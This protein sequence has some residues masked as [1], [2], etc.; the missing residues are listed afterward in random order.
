M[1]RTESVNRSREEAGRVC[2]FRGRT[3]GVMNLHDMVGA[4]IAL[5]LRNVR[6][7]HQRNDF[8]QKNGPRTVDK[9][10]FRFDRFGIRVGEGIRKGVETR[11]QKNLFCDCLFRN[12]RVGK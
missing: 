10:R 6:V 4:V 5:L 9:G 2:M 7:A 8:F 3:A 12:W 11:S 1:S